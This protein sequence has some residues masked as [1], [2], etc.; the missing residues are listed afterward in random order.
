MLNRFKKSS[1]LALVAGLS[2]ASSFTYA[3]E[4]SHP[5]DAK[6][7]AC[8]EKNDSTAGMI[9]C[10]VQAEQ[11]WDAEL[12]RVYKALRSKLNANAKKQL[13]DAQLQWLKYR[14]AEFEA[15]KG[16]YKGIYDAMG[17]GTMWGMIAVGAR[18]EIVKKRVLVLTGYLAD[19]NPE[20]AN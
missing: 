14:N 6:T 20:S 8:L 4:K 19:F 1:L 16:I 17:G 11:L 18:A 10:S 2:L 5:I 9:E 3:V 13:K 15:I 12:N 7:D